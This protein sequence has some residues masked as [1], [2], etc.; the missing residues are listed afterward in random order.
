M[1]IIDLQRKMQ[2]VGRIRLGIKKGNRPVKIETFRFTSAYKEAIENIAALYGGEME[3]W[4]A[5]DKGTQ[6][7]EVITEANAITIVVVPGEVLSQWNERWS[8]GGCDRR[9]DGQTER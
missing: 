6:Q 3:P 4:K 2:Q 1:P 7:Y 9:C 5:D 8:R